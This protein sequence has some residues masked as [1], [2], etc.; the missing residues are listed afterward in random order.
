M[1]NKKYQ[2]KIYFVFSALLVLQLMGFSIGPTVVVQKSG[3]PL[4]RIL[5]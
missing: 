4:M 2:K 1:E 3:I 5:P